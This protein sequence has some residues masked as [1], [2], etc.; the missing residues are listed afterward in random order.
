MLAVQDYCCSC[1]HDRSVASVFV[2][3]SRSSLDNRQK[4]DRVS[5]SNC[6]CACL[7]G[8]TAKRAPLRVLDY[9]SNSGLHLNF[10][11]VRGVVVIE[12]IDCSLGTNLNGV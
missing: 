3:S 12:S 11:W 6:V 5:F 10:V 4:V 8:Q 7:N 2:C 1:Y 9:S